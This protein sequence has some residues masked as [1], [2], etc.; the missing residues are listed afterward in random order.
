MFRRILIP[1]DGSTR[2]ESAIPVAARIARASKGTIV[3]LQVVNLPIDYGMFL[4]Q[5]SVLTEQDVEVENAKA[6]EYLTSIAQ[7]EQMEGIGTKI[8]VVSGPIAPTL[9]SYAEPSRADL[10]VMSS[11]GYTG[12]KRWVLG[13]VADK[14]IRHAQVPALVLREHEPLSAGSRHSLRILVALDGSP[15]SEAVLDPVSQLV[16]ALSEPSQ[17]ALHLLRVVDVLPTSG[18]WR[19]QAN[20]GSEMREHMQQDAKVYLA[21][22]VAQLQEDFA[23]DYEYMPTITASVVTD[24]DVAGAIIREAENTEAGDTYDLIAMSTH[25][26]GG[27]ER[28]TAGSVT[29][30]TLHGT[31]LPLLI[32]R[33]QKVAHKKHDKQEKKAM[34][35]DA[36]PEKKAAVVDI[37]VDEIEVETWAGG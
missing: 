18:A 22:V 1:L 21:S 8:E 32:V 31:K 12:F 2:A 11:H 9:L 15:L 35:E 30:R 14:V 37:E 26:R 25:G 3:L 29:E 36:A 34:K 7:S 10:I 16:A 24:A 4:T 23:L 27:L 28:W 19:S 5:S 6:T 33:P 13:S 17:G 20:I